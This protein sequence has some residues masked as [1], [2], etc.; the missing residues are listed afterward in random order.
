MKI[1]LVSHYNCY[2][3]KLKLDIF[4][5]ICCFNLIDSPLL[6]DCNEKLAGV[7]ILYTNKDYCEVL[8]AH[9]TKSMCIAYAT[10]HHKKVCMKY[11]KII[12]LV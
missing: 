10:E 7:L 12:I 8:S 1:L 3:F 9:T 11:S 4:R 5:R 6:K 2:L